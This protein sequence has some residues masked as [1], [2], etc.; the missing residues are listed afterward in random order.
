MTDLEKRLLAIL[1]F[2]RE[3]AVPAGDLSRALGL[4]PGHAT[5]PDLRDLIR[6]VLRDEHIPIG[7]CV[8][9]YFLV[10]SEEECEAVC[11]SYE[12]RAA[13]IRERKAWL[14]EAFRE[15]GLALPSV[16][17]E[18]DPPRQQLTLFDDDPKSTP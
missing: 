13:A 4:T 10:D 1:P 8:D 15:R 14:R 11:A 3:N 17:T 5:F 9:G 6:T 2:G 12:Q 18:T 16:A 7:S